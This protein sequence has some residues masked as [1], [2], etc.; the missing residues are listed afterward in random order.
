MSL[1][2]LSALL[3]QTKKRS[4]ISLSISSKGR[5]WTGFIGGALVSLEMN[6]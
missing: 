1:T 4:S 2:Y 6:F 3:K 5:V